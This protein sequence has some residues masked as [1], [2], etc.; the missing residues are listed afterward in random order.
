M[1]LVKASILAYLSRALMGGM[2]TILGVATIAFFLLNVLPADPVALQ[3]GNHADARQIELIKSRM[4]LDKPLVERYLMFINDLSILS[5]TS[6][7]E[8][9]AAWNIMAKS[10]LGVYTLVLK[11]PY[12][13]KSYAQNRDV[14]GILAEALPESMVLVLTAIL[15]AGVIGIPTGV[16]AARSPGGKFDVVLQ[17]F[18]SAGLAVPAFVAAIIIAWIFGYLLHEWFGL[19]VTGSLFAYDFYAGRETLRIENLIL[20][21]LALAIRPLCVAAQL[22]RNSMKDVLEKNYIRTAKAFGIPNRIILFKHGLINAI[23]PVLSMLA[24]WIAALLAGSVFVEF[25]FGWKGLGSVMLNAIESQDF[26]VIIGLLL[27]TSVTYVLADVIL[28]WIMPIFDP[29]LR[30]K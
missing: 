3:A 11:W 2:L 28:K 12:L 1:R 24:A 18:T 9:L 13:G 14:G 15:L 27:A 17:L 29:T 7:Q 26:P 21:T 6:N 5:V 10:E 30:N 20:P 16:F 19:D 4:E 22:T 23:N 25:V 8:K